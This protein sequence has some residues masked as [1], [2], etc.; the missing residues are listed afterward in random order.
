MM[1]AAPATALEV[2]EPDLLLELLIIAFDAPA[3][4]GDVDET[5]SDNADIPRFL[6]RQGNQ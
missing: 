6:N 5:A 1:E 4:F 2:T 3:Q